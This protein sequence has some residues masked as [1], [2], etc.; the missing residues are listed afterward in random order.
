M[1]MYEAITRINYTPVKTRREFKTKFLIFMLAFKFIMYLL[2]MYLRVYFFC[3]LE[4]FN[5]A[6]GARYKNVLT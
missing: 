3:N 1:L 5:T 2:I 6:R 4:N